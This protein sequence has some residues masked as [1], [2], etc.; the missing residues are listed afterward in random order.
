[1]DVVLYALPASHPCAAVE[2]AL[3]LKGVGC[4]R[5]ELIPGPHRIVQK[6]IFGATTVPAVR[7]DDGTKVVGSRPIMRALDARVPE[8]RLVPDDGASARAEEWGD[9]VLQSLVRRVV[10][11]ALIRAPDRV[12]GYTVNAKLPVPRPLASVTAPL[13]ARLAAKLNDATDLNVRADLRA[14]PHHLDRVDTW[15]AEGALGEEAI[16]ARLQIASG[17]RLLMTVEDV[18]PLIDARPAGRLARD[19]FPVIAGSVGAGV[20]PADWLP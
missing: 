20:L 4:R 12:M 17:L 13:T 1:M 10:W 9:Q 19:V 16:A 5:I 15:I 18:R 6:A 7:F 14:L 3:A 11:A 8:P 2:R